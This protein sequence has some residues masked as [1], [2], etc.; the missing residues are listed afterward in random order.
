[1]RATDFMLNI[2]KKLQSEK[3]LAEST[4][5]KY[6]KNL[7]VLNNSKSFK[8]LAWVKKKDLIDNSLSPYAKSTQKTLIASLVSVLSLFKDK[9][10][11]NKIH[12]YWFERMMDTSKDKA[13][14]QKLTTEKQKKNWLDWE[15][16]TLIKNNLKTEVNTFCKNK[17]ITKKQYNKL[18]QY[19]LVSLY[20]DIPPRRNKDFQEMYV[21]RKYTDKRDQNKNYLDLTN[22]K[23]VFNAYK[24]AKK[25]GKQVIDFSDNKDLENVLVCYLKH[26]P[27]K[28]RIG[29]NTE[30]R[31]LVNEDGSPLPNDNSI[32]RILNKAFK[33][34]V[35]TSMLRHIFLTSKYGDNIKEMEQ[36]A[37][38]MGHS[39]EQQKDYVV[40]L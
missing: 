12:K 28:K 11:Y 21:V 32:T 40:A 38:D 18:L 1:M 22:S 4:S 16:I 29:K 26:H 23:F 13:E 2:L 14:S 34:N 31:F 30:F 15:Q 24:T 33:K 17:F 20:T 37:K 27:L 10:S 39:V 8:N 3:D 7:Y 19:V 35:G 9:P 25:Y 5:T 36:D 6:I